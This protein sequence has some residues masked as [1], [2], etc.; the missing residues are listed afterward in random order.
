MK[1]R[2][3]PKTGTSYAFSIVDLP[4]DTAAD[5]SKPFGLNAALNSWAN[6]PKFRLSLAGPALQF[7]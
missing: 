1:S 6:T 3:F 5:N 2:Y 4:A 7:P